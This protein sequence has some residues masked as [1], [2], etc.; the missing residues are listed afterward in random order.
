MTWTS[1]G[2]HLDYTGT[3]HSPRTRTWQGQGLIGTLQGLYRESRDFARTLQGV[4][5]NTWGSVNYCELLIWGCLGLDSFNG[6]EVHEP[7]LS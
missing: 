7:R 4:H 5:R 2:L 1:P 6:M 3:P